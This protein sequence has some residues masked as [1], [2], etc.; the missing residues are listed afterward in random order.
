[1]IKDNKKILLYINIIG[2]MIIISCL[3]Y[4]LEK[5]IILSGELNLTSDLKQKTP[6]FSILYPEHRTLKTSGGFQIIEYP[7]Y[8]DLRAPIKFDKA[9]INVALNNP[10]NSP[11][12]ISIKT[13]ESEW[14]FD[15]YPLEN[16]KN[17][18]INLK[19]AKIENG[20]LKF[21]ISSPSSTATSIKPMIKFIDARIYLDNKRSRAQSYKNLLKETY[22]ELIKPI[23]KLKNKLNL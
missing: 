15:S 9:N 11:I 8:F 16:N 20:N 21:M 6:M 18:F 14:T 2:I 19:N 4:F 3:F 1:M 7:V 17:I 10:D 22:I 13:N 12:N 5:N 23:S